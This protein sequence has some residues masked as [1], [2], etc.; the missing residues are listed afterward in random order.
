[1]YLPLQNICVYLYRISVSLTYLT[2]D[3]GFVPFVIIT[4]LS[5]PHSWLILGFVTRV[6]RR[7]ALVEQELLTL[8]EYLRSP[9]VIS[10]GHVVQSLVFSVVFCRSL[11]V[12]LSFVIWLLYFLSSGLRLLITTLVTRR[13]DAKQRGRKDKQRSTKHYTEVQFPA[14]CF[15]ICFATFIFKFLF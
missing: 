7:V 12:P 11:C 14:I 13:T 2:N 6:T 3:H 1:M 10:R 8:P 5:F 4:I 15:C 9:A